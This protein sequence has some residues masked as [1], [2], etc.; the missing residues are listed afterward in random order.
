MSLTDDVDRDD[1]L[2][3]LG[4]T[5]EKHPPIAQVFVVVLAKLSPIRSLLE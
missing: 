1:G 2:S 4:F 3:I 5:S